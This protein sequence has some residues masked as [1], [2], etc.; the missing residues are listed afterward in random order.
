MHII[1]KVCIFLTI[2]NID[3]STDCDCLQNTD[4]AKIGPIPII[5]QSLVMAIVVSVLLV[6]EQHPQLQELCEKLEKLDEILQV[7]YA[8]KGRFMVRLVVYAFHSG[9]MVN[10]SFISMTINL[11]YC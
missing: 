1:F 10:N 11:Q 9:V 2:G 4:R 3:N 5:G 6:L 8:G 7:S